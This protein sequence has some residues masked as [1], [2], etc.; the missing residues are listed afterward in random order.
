MNGYII[1]FRKFLN[2]EWYKNEVTKS[3]FLHCILK[4]NWEEK[5]FE[6]E[7]IKRGSFITT[8]E[9]LANE[10]GYTISQ[11]RTALKHL[12]L[13]NDLAIKTTNKFRVIT[14]VNYEL[15]QDISKQNDKQ[16][17]NKSQTNRKQIATTNTYNT[18]NTSNNIYTTTYN[19]ENLF[20]FLETNFGRTLSP[21]EFEEVST[22]E[23]SDLTRYAIRQAVLNGKYS[24]KYISKI[25]Y[26]WQ[27][28]NIKTVQD[29]Q[30][31]EEQW[32]KQKTFNKPKNEM[33]VPDW[34]DKDFEAEEEKELTEDERR[35][36]EAIKNGTYRA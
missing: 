17:A 18:N 20:E 2:W 10:L 12:V 24:I 36:I 3:V 13:T 30:K 23:D 31:D 8:L 6:G 33:P 26:Q 27:V 29:A 34:F 35:E 16:I 11:I 9:K 5:K 15:Y 28:R 4:A 7:I 19:G 1:L 25:L 21:I 32:N 14:V 22:W